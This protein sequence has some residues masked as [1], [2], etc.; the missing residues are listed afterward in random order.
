[1]YREFGGANFIGLL[2]V[3]FFLIPLYIFLRFFQ[4]IFV[5]LRI[6]LNLIGIKATWINKFL[7]EKLGL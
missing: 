3:V 7:Y 4:F 5:S 6:I 2:I 1:M